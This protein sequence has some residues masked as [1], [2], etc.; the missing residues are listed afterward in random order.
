MRIF[1][2]LIL[3]YALKYNRICIL[4]DGEYMIMHNR[5]KNSET[6]IHQDHAKHGRQ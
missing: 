6:V 1:L 5:E 2:L 3:N 4:C